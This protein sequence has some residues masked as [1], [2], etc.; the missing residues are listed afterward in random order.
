MSWRV[1]YSSAAH[2]PGLPDSFALC[3]NGSKSDRVGPDLRAARLRLPTACGATYDIVVG[4]QAGLARSAPST[5]KRYVQV[6]CPAYAS[7]I[8]QGFRISRCPPGVL[9]LQVYVNDLRGRYF[10]IDPDTCKAQYSL[11][12]DLVL[13]MWSPSVA[14]P[15]PGH[16]DQY[17]VPLDPADP[18]LLV[19]VDFLN[20][21]HNLLDTYTS[22]IWIP[23]WEFDPYQEDLSGPTWGGKATVHGRVTIKREP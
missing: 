14:G 19:N 20:I 16:S 21:N 9:E 11:L 2:A 6:P 15:P 5:P 8:V 17:R 12:D 13:D 4:A 3:S 23:P 22:H 7:V 18:R 10:L 1:K